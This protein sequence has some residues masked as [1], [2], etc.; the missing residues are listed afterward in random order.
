MD[1]SFTVDTSRYG[2]GVTF[3]VGRRVRITVAAGPDD[4]SG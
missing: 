2:D 3:R 4:L 1:V